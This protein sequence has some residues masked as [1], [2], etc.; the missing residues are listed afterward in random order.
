M[1]NSIIF[2]TSF[3]IVLLQI[4][5]LSAIGVYIQ[6]SQINIIDELQ[7]NQK[8]YI[9]TK[10]NNIEKEAIKK[11]LDIL[12]VLLSSVN[13]AISDTLYNVDKDSVNITNKYSYIQS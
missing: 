9:T 1:K 4:I 6:N 12:N 7:T 10:L 8:N 2:K 3:I 5:I 13:G 11:E